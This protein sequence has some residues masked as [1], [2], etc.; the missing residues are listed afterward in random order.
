MMII[1]TAQSLWEISLAKLYRQ[2]YRITSITSH[3][4]C[5]LYR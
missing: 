1:I 4:A 2:P 3:A 5:Y